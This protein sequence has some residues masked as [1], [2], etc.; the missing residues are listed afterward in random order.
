[1][2]LSYGALVAE[3]YAIAHPNNTRSVV[4]DSVVMQDGGDPFYAPSLHAAGGVMQLSCEKHSCGW[5]PSADLYKV[6]GEDFAGPAIFNA[7]IYVTAQKI[8]VWHLVKAI[9]AAANGKPKKLERKIAIPNKGYISAHK[10]SVGL[11]LATVCADMDFPWSA[12]AGLKECK[13]AAR[14][15]AAAIDLDKVLPFKRKTARQ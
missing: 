8:Y 11:F 7:L 13:K 15:G 10:Y 14:E 5:D 9:H 2:G 1:M 6:L 12:K 4:L 3:R